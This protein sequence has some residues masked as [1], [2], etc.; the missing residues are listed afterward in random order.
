MNR[1]EGQWEQLAMYMTAPEI[2]NKYS[3]HSDEIE[4][5]NVV[6][7]SA[8]WNKKLK[9]SRKRNGSSKSRYE[10]FKKEGV[11][12]PVEIGYSRNYPEGYIGEGHHRVVSME[13]SRPEKLLPVTHDY[14]GPIKFRGH[15]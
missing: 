5:S 11:Q 1:S 8:L 2:K 15:F 12:S 10:T 9:E 4:D 6:D 7:E 3:V 13:K 14:E